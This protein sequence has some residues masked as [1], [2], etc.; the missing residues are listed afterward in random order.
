[1]FLHMKQLKQWM[2]TGEISARFT[3]LQQLPHLPWEN[4]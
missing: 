4:H 2:V 3:G 1:M